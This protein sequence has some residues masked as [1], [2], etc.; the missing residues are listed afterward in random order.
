M[1]LLHQATNLNFVLQ[2]QFQNHTATLKVQKMQV[3]HILAH[4]GRLTGTTCVRRGDVYFMQA[5]GAD[6]ASKPVTDFTLSAADADTRTRLERRITFDFADTPL[7]DIIEFLRHVSQENIIV[8]PKV[9]SANP[10]LTMQVRDVSLRDAFAAI[11]WQSKT[12]LQYVD[13]ALV[14]DAPDLPTENR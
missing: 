10:T 3:R 2:P 8:M 14:F 9:V 7:T 4:L 5:I 13:G 6:Q 1:T 12:S 11:C